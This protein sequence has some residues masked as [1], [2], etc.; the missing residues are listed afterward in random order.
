MKGIGFELKDFPTFGNSIRKPG[1][2]EVSSMMGNPIQ[3][4]FVMALQGDIASIASLPGFSDKSFFEKHLKK[5]RATL[6][7]EKEADDAARMDALVGRNALGADPNQELGGIPC[8][9]YTSPSPRD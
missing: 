6:R 2:G 7:A 4:P 9:L 1:V 5:N 8:L 3:R